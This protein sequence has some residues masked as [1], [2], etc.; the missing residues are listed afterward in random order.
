MKFFE[1]AAVLLVLLILAAI[2]VPRV[3]GASEDAQRMAFARQLNGWVDA[4]NLHQ[5]RSGRW[6]AEAEPGVLPAGLDEFMDAANWAAETPV[7]GHWDIERDAGGS[8][9][10]LGVRFEGAS[11][12]GDAFMQDVDLRVDDGDLAAG[13]FRKLQAG[14]YYHLLAGD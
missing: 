2:V 14:G 12:R 7:G 6:P 1:L 13:R 10:A 9:A 3:G 5:A 4:V 11:D 8:E